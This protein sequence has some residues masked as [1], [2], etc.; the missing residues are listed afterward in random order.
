MFKKGILCVLLTIFVWTS[1]A[2]EQVGA[3]EN[4]LDRTLRTKPYSFGIYLGDDADMLFRLSVF[5]KVVIRPEYFSQ[6]EI[7]Q[8]KRTKTKVYAYIPVSTITTGTAA[9]REFKSN[10]I[11]AVPHTSDEF[12]VDI[13]KPKWKKYLLNTTLKQ[14]KNKGVAG[15][16]LAH[17]DVY[18][19]TESHPEVAE[20]LF[21]ILKKVHAQ[22]PNHPLIIENPLEVFNSETFQDK[23]YKKK[24]T[25]ISQRMVSFKPEFLSEDS[26]IP[27]TKKKRKALLSQLEVF[28]NAGKKIYTID[29][30]KSKQQKRVAKTRSENHGFVPFVGTTNLDTVLWYGG[31]KSS[32][33][34][35]PFLAS[36]FWNS[37][38]DSNPE[39][40]SDSDAMIETLYDGLSDNKIFLNVDVWTIPVYY[41]DHSVPTTSVSCIFCGPGFSTTLRIP[42][43]AEADPSSDGLMAIIDIVSK[44]SYE[45]YQAEKNE[46]GT[47]QATS[48]F[49]FDLTGSGRQTISATS[50]SARGAGVSITG[51]LIRRDEIL[52][53]YIPHA[54]AIA[55]DYPRAD[56]FVYPA[57]ATDGRS[58]E[59][60]AIPEGAHLQ[61]N[62]D[63]D[64]DSLDLSRE[65]KI[66]AQAL[67]EYGAFVVDNADGIAL[68]AEGR[69]GKEVTWEGL[70]DSED[71]TTIPLS[72]LRVLELGELLTNPYLTET[73]NG[74]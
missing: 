36:S 37:K 38:I 68:Y 48:G 51:G 65:G 69:Y 56:V 22:Y 3:N 20:A 24:F 71:V 15:F 17:F 30:T 42:E 13:T 60:Y 62:P 47:W 29:F 6:E 10:R 64:L 44:R 70:L 46:D 23:P 55:F 21:S 2:I 27:Q 31:L 11:K 25:G 49:S 4:L 14:A 18:P 67:Q 16:Y 58:T 59:E 1:V 74:F 5:Q 57:S 32:P 54:L 7:Q 72:E 43:T 28:K 19:Q 53:G 52:Q 12:F 33:T 61:L 35:R 63:L 45:L 50:T 73:S 34:T 8:L 26:Y 39:V 66:I 40:D 41:V 9:F